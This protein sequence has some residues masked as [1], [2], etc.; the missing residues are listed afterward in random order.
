MQ[1]E[2]EIELRSHRDSHWTY[3]LRLRDAETAKAG[4][5]ERSRNHDERTFD[6]HGSA[7]EGDEKNEHDEESEKIHLLCDEMAG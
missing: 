1:A 4:F 5:D 6:R 2:N 3:R 7:H